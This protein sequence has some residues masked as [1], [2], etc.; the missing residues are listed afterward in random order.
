MTAFVLSV[1]LA[2]ASCVKDELYDTP[3]PDKAAVVIT[4]DWADALDE[5]DV[6]A[7]YHI[8]MDGDETVKT[9]EA[10]TVYPDLLVPGKHSVFV[11]NEPQGMTIL[12]QISGSQNGKADYAQPKGGK[13]WENVSAL[14]QSLPLMR[15]NE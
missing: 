8:G 15:E 9:Q 14:Q 4:T 7:A 13:V 3:H 12:S 2:M 5:T 6:P 11:Y 10:T 1:T